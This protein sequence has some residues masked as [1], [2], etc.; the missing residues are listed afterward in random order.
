MAKEN[1]SLTQFARLADHPQ[2]FRSHWA[3]RDV[4]SRSIEFFALCCVFPSWSEPELEAVHLGCLA[5]G[6]SF[7]YRG[8]RVMENIT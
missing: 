5:W 3:R 2:N 7:V 6:I 8:I 1:S 4:H